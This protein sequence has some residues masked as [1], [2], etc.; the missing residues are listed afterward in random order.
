MNEREMNKISKWDWEKSKL[1]WEGKK[2][3]WSV[4]FRLP[5][6]EDVKRYSSQI[7]LQF[8]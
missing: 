3:S 6:G 4:S 1:Q 8:N 7:I 2:S 5:N